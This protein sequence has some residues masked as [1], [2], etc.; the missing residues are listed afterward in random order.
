VTTAALTQRH[1]DLL[2]GA[3]MEDPPL[4]P[5]SPSAISSLEGNALL[6]G[7]RLMRESIP[8]LQQA[9]LPL[10]T[11][12]AML[13]AA[14]DTTGEATF[15]EKLF[16]DGIETMAGSLL[17]ADASVLDPVLTGRIESFLDPTVPFGVPSLILCADPA[18]P[19]AVA[20][21]VTARHYAEI[22]PDVEVVVVEGAG[23]LIHDEL[24]SREILRRA[25]LR[26]LD[27]VAPG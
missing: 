26:F 27:R 5:T 18:K 16:A 21:P 22:S 15:G 12:V 19:D 1:A 20:S 23:H 3:V 24:A 6:D 4:G 7:F 8:A 13:G 25:V 17:E 14:P 2:L 10:D 11:I 9:K